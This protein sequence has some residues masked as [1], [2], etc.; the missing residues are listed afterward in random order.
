MGCVCN[1]FI[2]KITWPS[3]THLLRLPLTRQKY[4]S[5]RGP[6]FGGA[7]PT[8]MVYATILM[9]CLVIC[10]FQRRGACNIF[11]LEGV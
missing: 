6:A 5:N 7:S 3:G 10:L 1:Q 9:N 2:S 4:G 11:T 8:A